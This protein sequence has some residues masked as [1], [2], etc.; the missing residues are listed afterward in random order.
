M[1]ITTTDTV[2]GRNI[3]QYLGPVSFA[4][5]A[6]G[7]LGGTKSITKSARSD[8]EKAWTALQEEATALGADAVV[9][10]RYGCF[11]DNHF[12]LGTA[13]KLG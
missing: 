7:A 4:T 2:E 11:R 6:G 9:G 10:V 13:V 12:F 5:T 3:V 8:V 1:I